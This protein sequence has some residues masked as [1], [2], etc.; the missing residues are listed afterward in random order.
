VFGEFYYDLRTNWL[1]PTAEDDSA[2]M[3]GNALAL[4][5]SDASLLNLYCVTQGN[6][7]PHV[8][9]HDACLREVR[10][11]QANFANIVG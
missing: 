8:R 6:S 4:D 11:A 9:I 2:A 5:W 7:A 10:A 3:R 1:T